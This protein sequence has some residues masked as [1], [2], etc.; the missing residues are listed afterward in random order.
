M[1][2]INS[3]DTV[4][5][6]TQ[7]WCTQRSNKITSLKTSLDTVQPPKKWTIVNGF[8]GFPENG[9][10]LLVHLPTPRPPPPKKKR[11]KKKTREAPAIEMMKL[12]GPIAFSPH[13][14]RNLRIHK[15]LFGFCFL[16]LNFHVLNFSA[17]N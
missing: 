16:E 9:A 4:M 14:L 8:Q 5:S 1:R 3:N 13:E 6:D 12:I 17:G 15:L 2:V 11:K 7:D 10:P